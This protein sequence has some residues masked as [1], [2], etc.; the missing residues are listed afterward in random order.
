MIESRMPISM[1]CSFRLKSVL[2]LL[3]CVTT[4]VQRFCQSLAELYSNL[5]KPILDVIIYNIQLSRNIGAEGLFGVSLIVH[6]SA[7][8]LRKFTPPFG[9]LVAEEQRLEVGGHLWSFHPYSLF[10]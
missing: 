10:N 1:C 2:R 8:V 9:K 5:A 7:W 6:W 3:R 4:D